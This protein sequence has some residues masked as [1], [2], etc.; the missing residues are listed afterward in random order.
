M[1]KR[2]RLIVAASTL[3]ILALSV[4]VFSKPISNINE[5]KLNTLYVSVMDLFGIEYDSEENTDK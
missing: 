3:F 1:E 2:N 4:F 5:L